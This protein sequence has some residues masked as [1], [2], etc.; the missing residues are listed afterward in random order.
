MA[1]G[2]A[3]HGRVAR[4]LLP[5]WRGREIDKTEGMLL[6]FHRAADAVACARVDHCAIGA[7]PVPLK[8]RAGLHVGP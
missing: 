1:S 5:V 8:A 2:W 6:M 3:G 4:D 7:L